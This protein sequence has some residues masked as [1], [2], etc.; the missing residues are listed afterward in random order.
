MK[1]MFSILIVFLLISIVSIESVGINVSN[2]VF[3]IK[4]IKGEI[5]RL[6]NNTSENNDF[7]LD[8][9]TI[10]HENGILQ[11]K[12]SL[13]QGEIETPLLLNGKLY[14]V[15]GKSYYSDNLIL[16]DI[17][18]TENYNILE[19]KI[20]NKSEN[21]VYAKNY[22]KEKIVLSIILEDKKTGQWINFQE[23]L[24]S[25]TF[26]E[27]QQ[28]SNML[29]ENINLDKKEIEE[30]IIS[31]LNIH[32]KSDYGEQIQSSI[33]IEEKGITDNTGMLSVHT[34]IEPQSWSN[35]SVNF[36]ELNRLFNDLKNP[37]REHVNL[38]NYSL[39]ESLFKGSGWKKD[40]NFNASPGWNYYA[41][42]AEQIDY[43][44]TQITTFQHNLGF[45]STNGRI[46]DYDIA[47]RYKDGMILIY[48]H[49]TKDLSV[50]Y[51]NFGLTLQNLQIA[52]GE[53]KG[54]NV[55]IA[56][57][58][59]GKNLTKR[60]SNLIKYFVGLIPHGDKVTNLWE[61]LT[62]STNEA[63]GQRERFIGNN[64][65]EQK[66][67]HDGKVYRSISG[68]LHKWDFNKEGANTNLLGEI[69]IGSDTIS[70]SWGI[71]TT[72]A[73]NL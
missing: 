67:I 8:N 35:I 28:S 72:V 63:L 70:L 1:K 42:S 71:K 56:Q 38:S 69:H 47:L 37:N 59:F 53:L 48:D 34:P 6:G 22:N 62:L 33:N 45:R 2:N 32:N 21:L 43:T 23:N 57:T 66:N 61:S 17:E 65:E 16:G 15:K 29:I 52:Q 20:E 40:T 12:G 24:N 36:Q 3:K 31:L 73:S 64:F 46:I 44:I 11:G 13:L 60:D 26:K 49:N 18:S 50:F 7:I 41:H 9:L 51:Y 19:F 5:L 4:N 30:K 58:L 39:P 54:K 27:L 68:T 10:N 14:P 55:Y 25:Q